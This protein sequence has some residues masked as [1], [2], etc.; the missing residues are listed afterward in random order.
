MPVAWY[1]WP[2][3]YIAPMGRRMCDRCGASFEE[4]DERCLPCREPVSIDGASR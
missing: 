3:F 1:P 2:P 4:T